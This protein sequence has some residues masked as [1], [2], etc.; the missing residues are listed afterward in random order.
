M[1]PEL[2]RLFGRGIE[3]SLKPSCAQN[4]PVLDEISGIR[5]LPQSCE[6]GVVKN[7]AE[8]RTTFSRFGV[9]EPRRSENVSAKKGYKPLL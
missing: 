6:T 8:K 1:I 9:T 5:V 7:L 3:L 2:P 4:D